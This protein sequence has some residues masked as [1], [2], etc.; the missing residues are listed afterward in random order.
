MRLDIVNASGIVTGDGKTV[1]ENTSVIIEN[2]FITDM[3][4]VSYIAYNYDAD[5]FIDAKGGLVIPGVINI[6]AHGC[7]LGPFIPYAW[8]MPPMER[9]LF[10]MDTHL[11]EGTTTI[12]DTD[13]VT[14]PAE[15]EAANKIHP[16][17]IKTATIHTPGNMKT[18]E[19]ID[20]S[21][22]G[23]TDL[24]RKFTIDEAVDQGAVAIG[25][26]GSPSTTAGNY[27]KCFRLGKVISVV[28]ARELDRAVVANDEAAIRK[29]VAEAGLKLTVDEAKDLVMKTSIIPIQ[30]CCD[31]IR[32]TVKYVKKFDLPTLLHAEPCMK[33][34]ILDVAKEVGPRCIS[35]HSQHS[36]TPE[37]AVQF[38]KELKRL[39]ANVEIISADFYGAK[40]VEPST[41]PTFALLREGLVDAIT[42]DYSGGYHEP[43]LL[44]L[45]KAIEQKILTL[46]G[47]IKLATSNPARIVPKVAINKGLVE[48]GRVA[49]L[50]IVDKDDIS[51]VKCVIIF[52][53][54]VV[55]EGRIIV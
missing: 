14:L 6:H 37:Q 34:A 32:E 49:D 7:A 42:T 27:E 35:A 17:N 36:F 5:R 33:D 41:E 20:C 21:G 53:R 38:G 12:L 50:C 4:K 22:G 31:A 29:V 16:I 30:V 18:F 13:G 25:E 2:G 55:E 19:V 46:P 9:W 52:G 39:G 45:Q 3:P 28:H 43:I 23:L 10:N 11:L 1:L 48:P 47:A 8:K 26:V 54:M 51:K 24:H 40:Q 15:V 44:V